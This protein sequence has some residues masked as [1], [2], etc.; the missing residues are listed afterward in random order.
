MALF[1]PNG[2]RVWYCLLILMLMR[3]LVIPFALL[4]DHPRRYQS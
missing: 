1:D 2:I 3:V 4:G